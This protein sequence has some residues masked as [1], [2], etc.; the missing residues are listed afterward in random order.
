MSFVELIIFGFWS[1]FF[2]LVIAIVHISFAIGVYRDAKQ[3]G[4]AIF[5]PTEIWLLA[6]IFGG[7]LV[8]TAY[9]LM[10]HSRLNPAI[11]VREVETKNDLL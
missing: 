7:V 1:V 6:T 3:R 4:N 10:H 5:V 11:Q 8:A 9:W 2:V